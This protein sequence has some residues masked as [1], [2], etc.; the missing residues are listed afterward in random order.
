MDD[1]QTITAIL[2]GDD[3]TPEIVSRA[4]GAVYAELR[5]IASRQLRG[6][7]SDHSLA[8]ADLLHEAYLR[9]FGLDRVKFTDR[10]HF[11]NTAAGT[12]RRI[13]IDHERR[14]RAAKR[15]PAKELRPIEEA[16]R[17]PLFPPTVDLILLSDLLDDLARL[18][19][20]QAQI[21]EL[22]YFGGLTEIEV[23]DLLDTSRSTLSREL[24]VAKL[25]LRRKMKSSTKDDTISA[26]IP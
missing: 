17:A 3:A 23:A 4:F 19:P 15:I 12:M 25:W 20:R 16:D 7:R 1:P 18:N 22:R 10:L 26:R 9:L 21:V 5:V 24:R 2:Q 8:T 13:L 11:F 6:E 14:R